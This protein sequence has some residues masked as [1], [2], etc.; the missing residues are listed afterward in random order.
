MSTDAQIEANTINGQLGG[1]KTE[2]GKAVSRLNATKHGLT[3]KIMTLF[4][5]GDLTDSITKFKKDFSYNGP[6]ADILAERVAV[7]YA[8][9]QKTDEIMGLLLENE[10]EATS[11]ESLEKFNR[12]YITI[13]NRLYNSV[14]EYKEFVIMKWM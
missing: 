1:P 5:N 13:E 6:L 8:R 9:M 14:R 7:N 2:E 11:I 3:S 12:Y 4:T 10:S